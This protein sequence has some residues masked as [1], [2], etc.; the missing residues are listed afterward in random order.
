MLLEAGADLALRN[1]KGQTAPHEYLLQVSQHALHDVVNRKIYDAT[2]EKLL[3]YLGNVDTPN[4]SGQTLLHLACQYHPHLIGM[5]LKAGANP[6]LQDQSG[7]T[8][9]HYY[10]RYYQYFEAC[11]VDWLAV[12]LDNMIIENIRVLNA[13]NNTALHNFVMRSVSTNCCEDAAFRR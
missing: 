11:S 2:F 8:S 10:C 6:A 9:L 5:L 7:S 12:L 1:S 4:A 13:T 3:R